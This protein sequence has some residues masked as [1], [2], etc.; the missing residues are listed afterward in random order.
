MIFVM[1]QV[2]HGN[3]YLR[4]DLLV[5]KNLLLDFHVDQS[6]NWVVLLRTNT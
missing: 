5:L 4:F 6:S 2:H 3:F 1:S